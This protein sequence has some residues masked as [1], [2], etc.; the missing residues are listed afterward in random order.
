MNIQTGEW[1]GVVSGLGAGLDSFFE[2]L[3]KAFIVF[4]VQD[5]FRMFQ[6]GLVC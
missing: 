4:G 3:L 5:D 6:V 2:Y 1:L